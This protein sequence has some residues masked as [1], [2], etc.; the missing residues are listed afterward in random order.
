MKTFITSISLAVIAAAS[1]FAQEMP[2]ELRAKLEAKSAEVNA[3]NASK[4]KSWVKKQVEAWETIQNMSF[5][6]DEND[7]K[8]V[9]ELADKKFP[10]D[11]VKQEPF[12]GEQASIASGLGDYKTQLGAAAYGELKKKFTESGKTNLNTFLELL[13]N[14]TAA[15][16]ELDAMTTDK[17]RPRTFALIKKAAAEEFPGNFAEQ[18]KTIKEI[19]SGKAAEASASE[20]VAAGGNEQGQKKRPATMSELENLVKERYTAQTYMTDGDGRGAA[21]LS[22]IQGKQVAF[23]P[24]AA[25]TP[26]LTLSNARGEQLEYNE[27]EIYVSKNLPLV[28]VFPKELPEGT[29]NS[30]FINDKQYRDLVGTSQFVVGYLKQKLMAFPVKIN[31]INDK[32]LKLN[33][34][35]PMSYSEGTLIINPNSM[36]TLAVVMSA[37]AKIRRIN[38]FQRSEV[39]RLMRDIESEAGTLE[40]RRLDN[41]GKWEK[42]SEDNYID[43]KMKVERIGNVAKDFV[44]LFST[45]QLADSE[46][47]PVIGMIVKKHLSALK[48]RMD[49]SSFER[50]YKAYMLDLSNLIKTEVREINNTDFYSGFE[51]DV[52]KYTEV[53]EQVQKT[54]ENAAK[55]QAFRN[56]VQE[57]IKRSQGW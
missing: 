3:D 42:F 32:I 55:S 35:L 41:L 36:E 45:T 10:L 2:A 57:D 49:K 12:I 16:L 23:I 26:G 54:F 50:A 9:K 48:K 11:F 4:A 5:S 31:A 34:N 47:S 14:E 33:N 17:M 20:T 21:F 29:K 39:N 25:F 28:L 8:L 15:K 22:K 51:G 27:K 13:Q 6:A 38:W 18:L 44:K 19:L 37:Q 52:K 40:A 43:Q 46:N 24:F 30:E 53:L 7:I 56:L 1:A